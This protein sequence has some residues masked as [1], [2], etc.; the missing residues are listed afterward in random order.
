VITS[1]HWWNPAPLLASIQ[2]RHAASVAK[3]ATVAASLA[4]PLASSVRLKGM[5]GVYLISSDHPAAL[6]REFGTGSHEIAPKSQ[7]ALRFAEGGFA[8]GDVPHPGSKAQPFLRPA[9]AGWPALFVRGFG[10]I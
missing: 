3:S 7:Q 2:R 4:G 8:R 6:F 9:A 1:S 10:V 5:G